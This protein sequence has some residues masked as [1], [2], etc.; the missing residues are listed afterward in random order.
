[1]TS[2]IQILTINDTLVPD[3]TCPPNLEAVCDISEQPAYTT[4]DEFTAAGGIAIDNC[5]IDSISFTLVSEVSD[6]NICPEVVTRTYQISDSC[7]NTQTCEQTIAINDTIVPEFIC[8]GNLE[9]VCDIGEFP[10]YTDLDE[11]LTAGGTTSDNCGIDSTSFVLVSEVSDGNNCPLVV[12]RIYQISDICGNTTTCEQLIT[13]NDTIAP[14]INCPSDLVGACDLSELTAFTNF[15]DFTDAGGSASDNCGIDT[16]SF[17]LL[18]EVS[19]GDNCPLIITRTYEISDLCGN[20]ATCQQIVMVND[21]I[22]P[23]ITCPGDLEAVCDISE[24]PAYTSYE[25]FTDAGGSA[26][27]NCGVDITSFRLVSEVSD[28]S[29][30]P[31]IITRVYEIADL[32]G[33]FTSCTQLIVINDTVPPEITCPSDFDVVCSIDEAPAYSSIDDFIG[34]GGNTTDNCGVDSTSFRLISEV[35]D[36][37]ICPETITRTYEISDS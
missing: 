12:T 33:I 22:A 37:N 28:S 24:Q 9:A 25:E 26:S 21:T 7:G 18:D 20:L 29:S 8:P 27:D 19:N 13:I 23:E 5:G 32:C 2:C 10:A 17:R 15:E 30:C 31:E 14:E 34:A 1:M 16:T 11:F 36:G 3:F 4:Y 35:S 6:G